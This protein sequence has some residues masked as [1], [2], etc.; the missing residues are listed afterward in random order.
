MVAREAIFRKYSDRNLSEPL[1]FDKAKLECVKMNVLTESSQW[2][3]LFVR[4]EEGKSELRRETFSKEKR[5]KDK[6]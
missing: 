3:C 4:G 5:G 2:W 6:T 1:R